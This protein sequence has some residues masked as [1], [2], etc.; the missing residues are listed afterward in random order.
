MRISDWSSDV[1]SSD[2]PGQ[3]IL[4]TINL[5]PGVVFTNNDAYGSSGGQLSI[6]GFSEDRI[7]LTFD[8]VPLNDSGNYAIYS[9]QQLD[10]ELI[11][12]VNVN[13]G[14]TDVDSPTAAATGS[15]V[16]YRTMV[17]TEDFGVKVSGSAGEYKFFRI[18][19]LVNTGEFTPFGTRAFFSASTASNDNPFNNYGRVRKKQFNARVWQPVGDNGDFVSVAGHY[20]VNRNNFFGSVPLRLD[21]DLNV[22]S[23]RNDRFP[24]TKDEREYLINYPCRSEEHTS[25]LQSLMRN[26]Y[27]VFCLKKK[28]SRDEQS[29][30]LARLYALYTI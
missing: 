8:G 13:L 4:D 24:I 23:G 25:E 17:P 3:T 9:N 21:P 7:S 29:T 22:G 14:T 10:P 27:A 16:N 28:N 20:N 26:S 5:V 6:R 18:F 19:G 2:L 30:K 15:T 11:E 1:C 12:Q